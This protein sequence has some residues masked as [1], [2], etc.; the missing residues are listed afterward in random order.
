MQDEDDWHILSYVIESDWECQL[1]YY[2]PVL[3][4]L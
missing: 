1:E 4:T 2:K 3:A